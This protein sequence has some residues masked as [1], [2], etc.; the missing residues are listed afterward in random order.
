MPSPFSR[1]SKSVA[2][3]VLQAPEGLK[4][5]EK[6]QDGAHKLIPQEQRDLDR[7]AG[8]VAAANKKH[9]EQTMLA[10]SEDAD[11]SKCTVDRGDVI[12]PAV[13]RHPQDLTRKRSQKA[14]EIMA[15]ETPAEGY[16]HHGNTAD[17]LHKQDGEEKVSAERH[18]GAGQARAESDWA[19]SD[20]TSQAG[21]APPQPLPPVEQVLPVPSPSARRG[22]WDRI[23]A[24]AIAELTLTSP[25][26]RETADPQCAQQA[27]FLHGEVSGSQGPTYTIFQWPRTRCEVV[28]A[29]SWKRRKPKTSQRTGGEPL[30][31]HKWPDWSA[32]A[33][34][35][36]VLVGF[37]GWAS[38]GVSSPE[39]VQGVKG[40]CLLIPC[41]FSFPADV[42]VPDGITT[43]W[44]YDYSGRQWVVSHSAD[45]TRVEARFRG[46]AEFVGHPDHRVCNLL[47]KDLR[48]EDSGSYNFRFEISE[49]NR[50]SDV[51]GTLVTVTEEPRA[52]TIASP[53]ELLEG[54]EVDFNCSTPYM[55]LQEKVSLQWQGQDPARSV[56][57][58]SHKSD[59]TGVSHL[60]TLH[61]AVSWQDHGRVLHCQL[62]MASHSAQAEI[63]LQVKYAPKGVKILLSPSE[64]NILPGE[65]VTLTCQVNSSYP[66]VS[67]ITW[68]KD[69]VL[70][71]GKTGML[72]LFQAAWSDAGV[73]TC[74]AGNGVGSSV[75]PPLSLHVFMA[76]VQVS[77]AGAILENQTVTL[78][79]STPN[80][81]PS[82][83]RYS[84]Y[85]NH[86]PLEDAHSHTLQLHSATRADTGY[87]FCEV[88]NAQ[89]SER[90]GAVSVV[91]NHPPLIP[92]LTAFLE[93]Q[94]GLVGILHCSVVSEPLATL[95]LSRGGHV[96]ASTSG[97]G[98]HSPRFS[99]TSGP[100]SLH[101]EIRDLEE[102]DSG[103]YKCS[104]TNSLG[105]AT[106]TLDFHANAARLLISPAAEV[107]EGQAVTLSCRSGLRPTPDARFSWYLNGAL[108]HEG[109]SSSL[110]LPAA[111]STDAGSYH[112]RAQDS[113]STSSPSLPAVLTV[114]CEQPR[115]AAASCQDPP[116]TPPSPGPLTLPCPALPCPAP[117]LR[118]AP[119]DTKAEPRSTGT[120]GPSASTKQGGS[121]EIKGLIPEAS[122]DTYPPRQPIFTT[123]LDFDA[124]GAGAGRRGL[125]LCRVDSDPP[126]RL[127]LLHK[128]H[129]VAT[130]L[131][132]G[133]G[134]STCGGCSPRMKVTKAPNLLRIEIHN[135]LLEEEGLYLCE[136]SNALGNTSASATFNGQGSNQVKALCAAVGPLA[137]LSAFRKGR[138]APSC[139]R[140]SG[141]GQATQLVSEDGLPSWDSW[142]ALSSFPVLHPSLL[143]A[144]AV[145]R[146]HFS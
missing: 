145:P 71:R 117:G 126:A 105:N 106:S 32:A 5:A 11:P 82:D 102:A 111:S 40:S 73:Y 44:Y 48:P 28:G 143:R 27:A 50:W 83:L 125:L 129:V 140:C 55:C 64:R 2:R 109:P 65:L 59:P 128:D 138:A 57:S 137:A 36:D 127:Q 94:V 97:D 85:K 87:Y 76:E 49:G 62:S 90:S 39:L 80:Q 72:Q 130:S 38:W 17:F 142:T 15:L 78:G 34:L 21:P 121:C 136:A 4:M 108:L 60:E 35:Q 120:D 61:M 69:G 124:T 116:A 113:H 88:Q 51:K 6:D 103:E 91:V 23:A 101:L 122:S 93:T 110:L 89:G 67:S 18:P 37:G 53:A 10:Y 146:T 144:P 99:S 13:V 54:T 7:I 47:L 96:L 8:Q 45:P 56:T 75:S 115:P 141:W 42:E 46:R 123:R 133:G 74:Q 79:C 107:V 16:E 33:A 135:P 43:I 95:V 139:A 3:L 86:V 1:G 58:S 100:N 119:L 12:T 84:W 41:I 25:V 9:L 19:A 63:H 24:L 20:Q 52:P 14:A 134:C 77:P 118:W 92:V 114:L 104:A 70:L 29:S 81:A 30:G 26:A 22:I 66:A 132:S 31:I 131:P 98:D 112:C 68:L